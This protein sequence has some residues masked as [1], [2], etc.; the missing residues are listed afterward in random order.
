MLI[1]IYTPF[2]R[3]RRDGVLHKTHLP[4]GNVDGQR[5]DF[6]NNRPP[7]LSL[8]AL[9]SIEVSKGLS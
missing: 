3:L 1:Q 9:S 8:P 5:R 6:L 4:D 7:A 2:I